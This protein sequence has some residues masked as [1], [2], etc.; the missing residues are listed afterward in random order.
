M[1]KTL[2]GRKGGETASAT[3]AQA[4][5]KSLYASAI[6]L[7]QQLDT[8][9][10]V[11]D[12][13]LQSLGEA[14]VPTAGMSGPTTLRD[15]AQLAEWKSETVAIQVERIE[16]ALGVVEFHA[17]LPDGKDLR[18]TQPYSGGTPDEA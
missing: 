18:I 14:T 3:E 16:A 4:A 2:F 13:V 15:L 5:Q 10:G 7:N 8:A 17:S 9:I 1:L 11:L 6:A 12:G